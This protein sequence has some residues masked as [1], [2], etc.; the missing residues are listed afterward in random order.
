MGKSRENRL[1]LTGLNREEKLR[2][3]AEGMPLEYR[4]IVS[5]L[6]KKMGKKL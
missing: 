5:K 6:L 3:L 4:Q 1:G 2:K